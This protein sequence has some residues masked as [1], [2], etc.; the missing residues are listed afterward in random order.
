VRRRIAS[1][2]S[3]A[4]NRRGVPVDERHGQ[5]LDGQRAAEALTPAQS[6]ETTEASD[7]IAIPTNRC[8][9]PSR[10]NTASS[11]A[12]EIAAN[13]SPENIKNRNPEKFARAT[14]IYAA[15]PTCVFGLS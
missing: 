11:S 1:D 14:C 2:C 12:D 13:S 5:Q 7:T 3:W 4:D 6:Q 15:A 10:H 9:W 8:A